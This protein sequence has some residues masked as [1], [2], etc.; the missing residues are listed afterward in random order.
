[1][2]IAITGATGLLGRNLL[3]EIIKHHWPKLDGLEVLLLGRG[4]TAGTLRQRM[5]QIL[6]DE[7][8]AYL[9]RAR[10]DLD[11]ILKWSRERLIS[12]DCELSRDGLG[13]TAEDYR[14]LTSQPIDYFFHVAAST[15]LRDTTQV[16]QELLDA[17]VNGTA[18]LLGLVASMR[19]KEFAYVGSAYE[20]GAAHGIVRPDC[21]NS[22][23]SFRNPYERSKLLAELRV[24]EFASNTGI[25][26]RYFRP[27][28]I[29]GK[30]IENHIGETNKFDVFY[31]WAAFF[32][33]L[34]L[35]TKPNWTDRYGENCDLPIRICCS[36]ASGLNIVP[37]DFAAKLMWQTC[38]Q[39]HAETS[40]H[41]VNDQESGNAAHA[42][43]TADAASPGYYRNAIRRIST[44][45]SK[46]I[47]GAL[48]Q[49]GGTNFHTLH[50]GSADAF[51]HAQP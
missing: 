48:L 44:Q 1:M 5:V 47:G 22:N 14:V 42:L 4:A 26:C 9:G 19:V 13:I 50:H 28:I 29:C 40:F 39:G 25:Q 36:P 41:L 51:L 8:T 11:E 21:I 17:N 27:S 24:R 18:R 23:E 12:V 33:H 2:R 30:L 37:A 32:L 16:R 7:A 46:S 10:S 20:C 15:D 43:H 49:N 3:L 31:A 38:L 34:K 35:G 6:A 45:K